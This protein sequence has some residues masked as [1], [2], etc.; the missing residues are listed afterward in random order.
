MIYLLTQKE[1][2]TNSQIV[3]ALDIRPSSV[4]VMI[5]K[6]EEDGLVERHDSPD[7]KRISLISLTDKG[8]DLIKS[9]H[10]FKTE[11][12]DALFDGLTDDEKDEFG[13]LLNKLTDS[14]DEKFKK[15]GTRATNGQNSL[16]RRRNNSSAAGAVSA[17]LTLTVTAIAAA[18][19]GVVAAVLTT[20]THVT[21]T[22]ATVT[23]LTQ[24][25]RIPVQTSN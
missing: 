18:K 25:M 13:R 10:D 1:E 23:V 15:N 14:L 22:G 12:S 17:G 3:E 9:S 19:T 11:F 7:D 4:S 21:E 16:I 5:K 8:R 24:T 2:L 6:L 20:V